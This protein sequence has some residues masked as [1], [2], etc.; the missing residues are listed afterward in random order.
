MQQLILRYAD[1]GV[2]REDGQVRGVVRGLLG[3]DNV[4]P[5]ARA[6]VDAVGDHPQLGLAALVGFVEAVGGRHHLALV[7]HPAGAELAWGLAVVLPAVDL[8]LVGAPPVAGPAVLVPPALD[9]AGGRRR[10]RGPPPPRA[11]SRVSPCSCSPCP[12]SPPLPRPATPAG[13][14]LRST[15][16]P[17]PRCAGPHGRSRYAPATARGFGCCRVPTKTP[18]AVALHVMRGRRAASTPPSGASPDG[19]AAQQIFKF[20]GL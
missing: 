6:A 3:R 12:P 19:R 1:V 20:S 5:L 13:R 2:E 9:R 11:V 17:G 10:P 15:R 14:K 4:D 18:R 16:R 7:D 8:D